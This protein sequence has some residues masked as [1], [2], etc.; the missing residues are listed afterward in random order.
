MNELKELDYSNYFSLEGKI[1][2]KEEEQE[3]VQVLGMRS[4]KIGDD[5][6][7]EEVV[8]KFLKRCKKV[9]ESDIFKG[10]PKAPL[11][12]S[13]VNVDT[14]LNRMVY[15]D[16]SIA[17]TIPFSKEDTRITEKKDIEFRNVLFFYI[18]TDLS[19]DELNKKFEGSFILEG[20]TPKN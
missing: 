20:E 11:C 4:K 2:T 17:I 8:D 15:D 18:Y 3:Q 19:K 5:S 16:G 14:K 9:V 12:L 10:C 13:L 1:G 7:D 6:L